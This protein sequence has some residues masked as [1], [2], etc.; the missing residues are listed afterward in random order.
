MHGDGEPVG[1]ILIDDADFPWL[2]GR[3]GPHEQD[4]DL[5]LEVCHER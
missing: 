1:E 3:P 2:S 4:H 5:R